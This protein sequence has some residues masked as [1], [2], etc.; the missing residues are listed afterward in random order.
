MEKVRVQYL[1]SAEK[2]AKERNIHVID[3]NGSID[4]VF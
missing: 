3:G 2:L 1:D 4:E